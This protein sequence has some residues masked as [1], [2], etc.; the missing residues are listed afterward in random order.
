MFMLPTCYYWFSS[1]KY[2]AAHLIF[3]WYPTYDHDCL[4]LFSHFS[5]YF[6]LLTHVSAEMEWIYFFIKLLELVHQYKEVNYFNY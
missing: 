3:I 4:F 1:V 6:H 2:D 5:D